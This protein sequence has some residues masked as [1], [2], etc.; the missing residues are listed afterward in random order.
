MVPSVAQDSHSKIDIV[1]AI[2][3]IQNQHSSQVEGWKWIT[4]HGPGNDDPFHKERQ[5]FELRFGPTGQ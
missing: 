4:S 2:D 3:Q 1:D 5:E